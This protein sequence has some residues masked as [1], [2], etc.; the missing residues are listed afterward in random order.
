MTINKQ[1][2]QEGLLLPPYLAQWPGFVLGR[3]AEM[4]NRLFDAALAPLN[5]TGHHL[6]VLMVLAHLGPQ[7]Q[8]HIS[9]PVQIDKATMVRLINDLEQRGLVERRPHPGD[10]R[11]VLVHITDAG[12]NTVHE[13]TAIGERVT[14]ELFG[15]LSVAEQRTL[16]QLLVRIAERA[17]LDTT[18]NS[19]ETGTQ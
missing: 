7:V 13:A 6:G 15:V 3:V 17:P 14:E 10:R 1:N 19:T 4:G 5:I 11:A 18:V 12:R 16:R 8:A 9:D 2:E